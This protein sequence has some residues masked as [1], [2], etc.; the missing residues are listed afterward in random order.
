MREDVMS[1]I[2]LE[3]ADIDLAPVDTWFICNLLSHLLVIDSSTRCV[4]I[5]HG[6]SPRR[7][8]KGGGQCY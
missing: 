4:H 2:L 1:Q 3:Y 8:V 7:E 5:K 6:A